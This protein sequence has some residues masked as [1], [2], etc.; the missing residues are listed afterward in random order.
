MCLYSD[1]LKR[2]LSELSDEYNVEWQSNFIEEHPYLR[3]QMAAKVMLRRDKHQHN[4]LR[5]YT[6]GDEAEIDL[7]GFN[8]IKASDNYPIMVLRGDSML[9]TFNKPCRDS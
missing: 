7:L 4:I 8:V 2:P 1:E 6:A 3:L 9:K 5:V